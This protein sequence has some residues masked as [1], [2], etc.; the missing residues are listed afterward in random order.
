MSAATPARHSRQG[1]SV[2]V[3][4]EVSV[5]RRTAKPGVPLFM[6]GR[7]QTPV[8][9]P[10]FRFFS[11]EQVDQILREG[12]QH[13]RN[14]SHRAIERILKHEVGLARTD[15]WRRIRRL[16]NWARG[17]GA[18]HSSSAWTPEDEE[19]LRQGY[20]E[21]WQGKRAAISE[22][23]KRHLDWRPPA[24][25]KHAAKLRLVQRTAR[26]GQERAHAAWS[27]EDDRL[28][29]N[30]AGYK[31]AR[32]IAKLLHRSEASV[33][34]RLAVQS[35]SSRVH[36]EGFARSAIARE[37]HISV[38]T[39]QRFVA[40]GLLEVRDPRVTRASLDVLCRSGGLPASAATGPAAIIPAVPA[41]HV[42]PFA[43]TDSLENA[44]N[45]TNTGKLT[46]ARRV[47]SETASSLGVSVETVQ[48]MIACGALKLYDPRITEKSLEN[49]CHRHGSLI[50]DSRLGRETRNWLSDI[51]HF[52]PLADRPAGER[53]KPFRKHAELL[54]KCEC[55]RAIRGNVFFRHIK[56]CTSIRSRSAE[57]YPLAK[58]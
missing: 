31:A 11:A 57:G 56:K 38:R 9:E 22:I 35:K 39:I 43:P 28:L 46:R 21:G 33:R 55:G 36:Q 10:F 54:H 16:K 14:G 12:M 51:M 49:L 7:A 17:P 53:L 24:I 45:T 27:E 5:A 6:A 37:L 41:Q 25:W 48:D 30:L 2:E 18:G 19:T 15:L 3:S 42:L 8:A 20:Q 13:G 40:E 29:L 44:R 58:H 23:L 52:V 1:H 32:V 47:W 4:T 50:N 26:R 34:C